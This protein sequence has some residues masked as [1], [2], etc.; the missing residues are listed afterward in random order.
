[1]LSDIA[2]NNFWVGAKCQEKWVDPEI[3]FEVKDVELAKN[4]CKNCPLIAQC[5]LVALK[6]DSLIGV[7][8]G[9]TE[10]ER[11]AMKRKTTR[12]SRAGIANRIR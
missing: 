10:R 2:D 6:D 7:W 1:L 8:G 5:L 3:F 4:I 12:K 11:T 9:T